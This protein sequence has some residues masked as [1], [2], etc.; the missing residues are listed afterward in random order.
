ML[1]WAECTHIIFSISII[2]KIYEYIYCLHCNHT[3]RALR[4]EGVNLHAS[5]G[6]FL[7]RAYDRLRRRTKSL[8]MA[9]INAERAKKNPPLPPISLAA[10]ILNV[11]VGG[12]FGSVDALT[13]T[14]TLFNYGKQREFEGYWDSEK[15]INGSTNQWNNVHVGV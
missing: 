7:G 14:Y 11:D 8:W 13:F 3:L 1:W 9:L 2:K 10:R 15:I 12:I 6:I 5:N 4:S